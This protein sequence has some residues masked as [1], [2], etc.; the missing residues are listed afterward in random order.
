MDF[1]CSENALNSISRAQYA[2][3][4]YNINIY[5]GGKKWQLE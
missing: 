3:F 4:F 1:I 2:V 5:K